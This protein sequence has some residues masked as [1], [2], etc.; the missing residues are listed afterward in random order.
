MQGAG[1]EGASILLPI[2]R[3]PQAKRVVW[4]GA[5]LLPLRACELSLLDLILAG[6]QEETARAAGVK[7]CQRGREGGRKPGSRS[8]CCG[9]GWWMEPWRRI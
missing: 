5:T 4:Y 2:S 9:E 1:E 8:I 6:G 7:H 3:P